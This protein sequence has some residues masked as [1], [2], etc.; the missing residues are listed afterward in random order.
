MFLVLSILVLFWTEEGSLLSRVGIFAAG[1]G[2][3]ES[4][5]FVDF[6]VLQELHRQTR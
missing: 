5:G 2:V 4:L 3:S 1:S 6:S